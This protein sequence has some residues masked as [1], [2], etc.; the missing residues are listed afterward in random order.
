MAQ[1]PNDIYFVQPL[2]ISHTITNRATVE[3]LC[4]RHFRE[5][6]SSRRLLW[7]V[8]KGRCSSLLEVPLL[9]KSIMTVL[10][11]CS[12]WIHFI[13]YRLNYVKNWMKKSSKMKFSR[14]EALYRGKKEVATMVVNL[15][16]GNLKWLTRAQ[17]PAMTSDIWMAPG[18]TEVWASPKLKFFCLCNFWIHSKTLL[19]SLCFWPLHHFVLFKTLLQLI[20]F[21]AELLPP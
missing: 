8:L 14:G 9:L 21:S 19:C 10:W 6:L 2:S 13:T 11:L 3:P 18:W 17:T 20:Q 5:A 12:C 1:P 7:L 4:N 15:V 16:V